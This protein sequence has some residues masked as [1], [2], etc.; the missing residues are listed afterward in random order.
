LDNSE[1]QGIKK[2]LSDHLYNLEK[3]IRQGNKPEAQLAFIFTELLIL[4]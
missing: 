3:V 1:F 4:E 2:N